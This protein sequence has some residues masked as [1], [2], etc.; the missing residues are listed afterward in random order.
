MVLRHGAADTVRQEGA[1]DQGGTR[2]LG[3]GP[4]YQGTYRENHT[5]RPG[6]PVAATLP[7]YPKTPITAASRLLEGAFDKRIVN[8]VPED[9][10]ERIMEIKEA[11]EEKKTHGNNASIRT[12]IHEIAISNLNGVAVSGN[13]TK[14]IMGAEITLKKEDNISTG[15]VEKISK[16]IDFDQTPREMVFESYDLAKKQLVTSSVGLEPISICKGHVG[17]SSDREAGWQ[18]CDSG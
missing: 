14:M 6:R 4:G 15:Y 7:P 11:L 10:N 2:R 18:H 8:L 13:S 16:T 17:G 5:R 12:I 9:L 1:P 3:R